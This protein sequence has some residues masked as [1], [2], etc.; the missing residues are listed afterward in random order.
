MSIFLTKKGK[1]V[2]NMNKAL[3][4]VKTLVGMGVK[5]DEQQATALQESNSFV[6]LELI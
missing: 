6:Y 2:D 3:E 4:K 5:E 1:I